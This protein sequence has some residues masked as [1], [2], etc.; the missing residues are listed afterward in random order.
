MIRSLDDIVKK[1]K[2][3][4]E[5]SKQQIFEIGESAL[6]EYHRVEKELFTLSKETDQVIKEVDQLERFGKLARIRLVEVDQNFQKY[7]EAD[8]KKA[9]ETAQDIQVKLTVMRE[10]ETQ[11]RN[12]REELQRSLINLKDTAE[13]AESLMS[14]IGVVLE[15]LGGSLHSV[16]SQLEDLQYKQNISFRVIKA[17]EEERKRIAREIH[18][19]PAQAMANV[20]LR[21]EFCEKL[22]QKDKDKVV[23]ELKSLK[24]LVRGTLQDVRKIIFDLRPMALDDLGLIPAL[25]RYVAEYREKYNQAAELVILGQERRLESTIEVGAFRIIQESLNNIWKH[26]KA[27]H[28]LIRVELRED[29]LAFSITDNGVGFSFDEY[30][31]RENSQSMGL[32]GMKERVELLGGSLDIKTEPG[33]GTD[34]SVNIPLGD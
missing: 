8:I 2:S 9:Y 10:R 32:L 3:A 6:K 22:F 34:I 12:K 1:T 33:K 31:A 11:M 4:I 29:Y 24:S 13:K 27:K 26:A 15:F 17:Q 5:S 28:V 25:K 14:Q 20:V 23:E 30:L 19:G 18:D 7:T 21:V 16:N